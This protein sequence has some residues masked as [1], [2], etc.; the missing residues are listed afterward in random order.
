MAKIYCV[1]ISDFSL[2]ADND[3][4]VCGHIYIFPYYYYYYYC[5]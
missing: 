5:C 4:A 1:R 2:N 3:K